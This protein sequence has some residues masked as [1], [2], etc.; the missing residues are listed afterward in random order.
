MSAQNHFDQSE[1]E[2]EAPR[3]AERRADVRNEPIRAFRHRPMH[4]RLD[5]PDPVDLASDES[6]PASD[7]PPWTLGVAGES[8]IP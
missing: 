1:R 7:P 5:Q 3:E 2:S 6:F 8:D 4:T